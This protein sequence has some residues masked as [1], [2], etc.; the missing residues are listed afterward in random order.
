MINSGDKTIS[1]YDVGAKGTLSPKTPA[2]VPAPFGAISLAASPT[3]RG[4]YLA[5]DDSVHD[6]ATDGNTPNHVYQYTVD[7]AGR[8][9]ASLAG[10]GFTV[11]TKSTA[12]VPG[13]GPAQIVLT[14]DGR[15][16][17]VLT[18]DNF[19]PGD[20][21][22][23]LAGAV[24][25]Y[26]VGFDGRMSLKTPATIPTGPVPTGI[27][28]G[29]D[30]T[31]AYVANSDAGSYDGGGG[32]ISEYRI[33]GN[34]TLSPNVPASLSTGGVYGPEPEAIRVSPDG[35]SATVLASGTL[36]QYRV[37]ADGTLSAN[38]PIDA[39]AATFP[40]DAGAAISMA[41][42]ADATTF[43]A[44]NF[45]GGFVSGSGQPIGSD[46][47]PLVTQY[48]RA[49]TGTLS[50]MSPP[51][52]QAGVFPSYDYAT[53]ISTSSFPAEIVLNNQFRFPGPGIPGF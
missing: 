32:S 38:A 6:N 19:Y 3:R 31:S 7:S 42:N 9:Q 2:T 25:Q 4:V 33:A 12:V 37:A 14:A 29:A 48:R 28:L 15:N 11:L 53:G 30:G 35:S 18:G 45:G 47:P 46:G 51:E 50:L 41:Y 27:T 1:Q 43:Y 24:V 23:T 49:T 16:A 26:S 10:D 40:E 5:A 34:G 17:Y 21:G 20:P 44:T 39:P 8:L 36:L 13:N 52:V 22:T